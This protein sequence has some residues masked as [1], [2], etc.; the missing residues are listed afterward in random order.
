MPLPKEVEH[1]LE[2]HGCRYALSPHLAVPH[3][4]ETV[5]VYGGG[6]F[7]MIVTPPGKQIDYYELRFI[8]GL[9]HVRPATAAELIGLFPGCERGAEVPFGNLYGIA[10]YLDSTLACEDRVAFHAGTRNEAIQMRTADYRKLV[11]PIVVF[12][13]GELAV[14]HHH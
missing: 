11:D 4:A 6:E 14:G 3:I 1:F 9:P 8:L 10:V 12:L 7:H 2:A 13:A 5:V